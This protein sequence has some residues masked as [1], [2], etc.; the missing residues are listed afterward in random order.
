MYGCNNNF[1]ATNFE[2]TLTYLQVWHD[3]KMY[4]KMSFLA[5]YTYIYVQI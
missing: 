5:D 4:I 3:H 2:I 1:I